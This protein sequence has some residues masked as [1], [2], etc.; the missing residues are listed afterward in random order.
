MG[1]GSLRKLG[2]LASSGGRPAAASRRAVTAIRTGAPPIAVDFGTGSLKVLQVNGSH[3]PGL[4]AAATLDTPEELQHDPSKR[5]K[6]QLDALPKLVKQGGFKATRAVCAI[7]AS[8]MF[9]KHLQVTRTDGVD[10]GEIVRAAVAKQLGC[11]PTSLVCRHADAK[12]LTG[13]RSEVICFAASRGLVEQLM[14]ALKASKLEPVGIHPELQALVRGCQP[15]V[16]MDDPPTTLYLDIGRGC[17]SVVIAKGAE[18]RFARVIEFGGAHLDAAVA[19]QL[20]CTM[21]RAHERRYELTRVIPETS[22]VLVT[23]PPEG[24]SSNG[25]EPAVLTRAQLKP[26]APDVDLSEAMEIL[27]DEIKMCLRYHRGLFPDDPATKVVFVGGESRHV[28]MCEHIARV[29]RLGAESADPLARVARSGKEPT[30]GLTLD[31][32]QPGWAVALGMCLTPTDL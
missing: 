20:K 5:L 15:E 13:S 9:C 22:T 23:P 2:K 27:T 31:Q 14:G 21:A 10:R 12:E 16:V 32:P 7:P 19:S 29:L 17:T 1:L 30:T 28:P 3:P 25:T 26:I 18:I 4:V 24:G 6:F 8:T 11:D